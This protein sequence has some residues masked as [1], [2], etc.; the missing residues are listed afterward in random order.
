MS[1][2]AVIGG[3]SGYLIGESQNNTAFA[4]VVQARDAVTAANAGYLAVGGEGTCES[5]VLGTMLVINAVNTPKS[6]VH[7]ENALNSSCPK[8]G[9]DHHELAQIAVSDFNTLK[10]AESHLAE[11]SDS[12]KYDASEKTGS[13]ILGILLGEA[14][15]GL[16]KA[17]VIGPGTKKE[18]QELAR[19]RYQ[20]AIK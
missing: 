7:T 13:T 3:T 15:L 14:A 16:L 19:R 6:V 1:A 2:A 17:V 11:V 9:V 10:T 18:R 5:T 12:S 4:E 8:D 20:Y